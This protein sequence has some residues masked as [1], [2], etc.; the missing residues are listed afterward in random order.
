MIEIKLFEE[1]D[2][3][4]YTLIEG[5]PGVGLVGPMANSYIIE[6][7]SME[8]IGYISSDGFPPITAIH[9]NKPMFPVRIYKEAKDKLAVIISEFTIPTNL[10][11]Q[12]AEEITE[13]VRKYKIERIISI[14]GIPNQKPKDVA[15]FITSEEDLSEK[16]KK[17][18]IMPIEEGVV[19]GVS[20]ILLVNGEQYNIPTIDLLVEVNPTIMDP[21]YAEVAILNLNKIINVKINT[22]ELEKEAKLV[23]TKVRDILKKTKDSH[24]SYTK[25]VDATGPSMYA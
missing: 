11:Y 25:A 20:A 22:E 23:E 13:F 15:Y 19:A 7:L 12:L 2:L 9:G 3:A 6:S 8:Y 16:V 21:K 4:G 10:V 17:T 5:F 1:H 24:D 18:G 14:G